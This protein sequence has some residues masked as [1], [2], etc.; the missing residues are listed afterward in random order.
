MTLYDANTE[1]TYTLSELHDEWKQFKT[2]DPWNHAD[3]FITELYEILMATVNG[4]NDCD[5]I[6]LTPSETSK[7]IITIRDILRRRN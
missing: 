7:Y 2:E 4:R 3:D 6:G 5:I 1:R